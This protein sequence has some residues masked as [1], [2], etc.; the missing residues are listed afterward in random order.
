VSPVAFDV[1]KAGRLEE[2]DVPV[3]GDGDGDAFEG[4]GFAAGPEL[5]EAALDLLLRV[6]VLG[7]GAVAAGVEDPEPVEESRASCAMTVLPQ[8][9]ST[10]RAA[11]RA[12]RTHSSDPTDSSDGALSL[13]AQAPTSRP[14][15]CILT[16]RRGASSALVPPRRDSA[17]PRRTSASGG[18]EIEDA[19]WARLTYRGHGTARWAGLRGQ[20]SPIPLLCRLRAGRVG[21]SG[22][23]STRLARVGA[24]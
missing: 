19:H 22:P 17:F 14:P 7:L 20:N 10:S 18:P 23:R 4:E 13:L 24:G 5:V 11:A 6:T 9:S 3:G 15:F 21:P 12:P 16:P 8:T 1:A 2:L